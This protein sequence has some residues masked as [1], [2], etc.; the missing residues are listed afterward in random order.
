[1]EAD[2]VS[3]SCRTAKDPAPLYDGESLNEKLL[4]RLNICDGVTNGVVF[5]LS[6]KLETAIVGVLGSSKGPAGEGVIRESQWTVVSDRMDS[7]GEDEEPLEGP[8]PAR[9]PSSSAAVRA[10]VELVG[11]ALSFSP[12]TV[13]EA[14]A[15]DA[16]RARNLATSARISCHTSLYGLN[17]SLREAAA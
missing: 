6:V 15:G 17:E 16:A 5:V 4:L 7:A 1:M 8:T 3:C 13:A 11:I 9:I 14:G 2:P 12:T 10:V